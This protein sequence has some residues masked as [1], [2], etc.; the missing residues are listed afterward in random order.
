MQVIIK[1]KV[2]FIK[3][4]NNNNMFINIKNINILNYISNIIFFQ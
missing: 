1:L 2:T 4:Y 3:I